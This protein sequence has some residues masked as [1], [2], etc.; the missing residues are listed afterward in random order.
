MLESLYDVYNWCY[1]V[2]NM[3]KPIK[4]V[5]S[6]EFSDEKYKKKQLKNN[7]FFKNLTILRLFQLYLKHYL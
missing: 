6:I 5:F 7:H 2:L 4:T 3:I 1:I